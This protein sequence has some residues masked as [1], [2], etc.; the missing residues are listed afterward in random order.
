VA[1]AAVP[2]AVQE[3][4]NGDPVQIAANQA[5]IANPATESTQGYGL[6]YGVFCSEW[7]PFQPQSEILAM[8]KIAF[9]DYPDT[10]KT[11]EATSRAEADR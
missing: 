4:V 3:L 6:T 9:P 8:G 5:A 7:I 10:V 11:C 2:S 1:N